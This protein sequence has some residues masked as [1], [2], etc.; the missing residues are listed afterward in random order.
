M[1]KIKNNFITLSLKHLNKK[2]SKTLNYIFILITNKISYERK[3]YSKK[4]NNQT[5]ILSFH[6][7]NSK[8]I[9]NLNKIKKKQNKIKK[10]KYNPENIK[11]K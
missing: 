6:H 7:Q 9:K 10:I 1:K 5:S 3:Y 11:P 8:K 2:D 4:Y